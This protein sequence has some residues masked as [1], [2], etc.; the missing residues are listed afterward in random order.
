MYKFEKKFLFNNQ[1]LKKSELDIFIRIYSSLFK[2]KNILPLNVPIDQITYI[3]Y[4]YTYL[5]FSL[6]L[7][8]SERQINLLFSQEEKYFIISSSEF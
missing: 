8:M 3:I 6:G 2:M 5:S 4:T 1:L 7:G